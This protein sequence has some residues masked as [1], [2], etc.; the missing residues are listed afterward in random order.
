[1]EALPEPGLASRYLAYMRTWPWSR[2]TLRMVGRDDALQNI[3]LA[4][5]EAGRPG[6]TVALDREVLRRA[7]NYIEKQSYRMVRELQDERPDSRPYHHPEQTDAWLSG[8]LAH[9]EKHTADATIAAYDLPDTAR[10]RRWL[11]RCVPKHQRTGGK[12]YRERR[13]KVFTSANSTALIA[14]GVP[15]ATAWRASK[16]GYYWQ[17]VGPIT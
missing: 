13:R 9:Y 10:V 14:Q 1:M 17:K 16:R 15:R 2:R 4:W 12:K 7:W 3:W 6:G 8:L 11:G 5:L